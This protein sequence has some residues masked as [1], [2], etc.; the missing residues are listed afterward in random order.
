M[1]EI[2]YQFRIGKENTKIESEQKKVNVKKSDNK[3]EWY[4]KV[5]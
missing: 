3:P 2:E 5:E 1:C 4:C